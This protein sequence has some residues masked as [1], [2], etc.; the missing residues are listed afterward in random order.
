MKSIT[1]QEAIDLMKQ[2]GYIQDMGH[3]HFGKP[4]CKLRVIISNGNGYAIRKTTLDSIL[5]T[6]N[7]KREAAGGRMRFTLNNLTNKP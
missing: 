3:Y 6:E 1:K 2:G 4:V 5:K 7:V